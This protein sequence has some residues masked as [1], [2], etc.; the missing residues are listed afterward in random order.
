MTIEEIEEYFTVNNPYPFLGQEGSDRINWLIQR[1][2]ELEKD[3]SY[4]ADRHS[5]LLDTW[6]ENKLARELAK[7]I[8][9]LEEDL[10]LNA[11]MLARQTDLAREAETEKAELVSGIKKHRNTLHGPGKSWEWGGKDTETLIAVLRDRM[12]KM[13]NDERMALL[14]DLMEGYCRHCGS[15][16]LPCFCTRDD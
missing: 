13:T 5:E 10:S 2:K 12:T 11:S 9:E 16:Y 8:K 7:R 14:S 15:E 4:W 3:V 6:T 1:V